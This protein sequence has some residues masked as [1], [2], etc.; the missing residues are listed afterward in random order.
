MPPLSRGYVEAKPNR[1]GEAPAIN[2]HF[3]Y[4]GPARK[5]AAASSITARA[6]AR[7]VTAG[8]NPMTF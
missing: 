5:S 6:A 1:P 7:D 8:R 4:G 2:Q 3:L